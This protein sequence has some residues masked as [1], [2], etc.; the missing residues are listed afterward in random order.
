[1]KIRR[2]DM[3]CLFGKVLFLDA[4][5]TWSVPYHGFLCFMECLPD[6]KIYAWEEQNRTEDTCGQLVPKGKVLQNKWRMPSF[7]FQM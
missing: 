7:T 4:M 1:M 5:H 3:A 6:C 2:R